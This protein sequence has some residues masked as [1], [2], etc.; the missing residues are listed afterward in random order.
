MFRLW[1]DQFCIRLNSKER[2]RHNLARPNHNTVC[3]KY[4][5]LEITDEVYKLFKMKD[6]CQKRIVE[7]NIITK[8]DEKGQVSTF[9][10]ILFIHH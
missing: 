5:Q 6:D 9:H 10:G 1:C 4:Y 8:F 2:A 3:G 7:R